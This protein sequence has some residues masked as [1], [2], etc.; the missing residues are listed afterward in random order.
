[1]SID[2]QLIINKLGMIPKEII[3]IIKDFVFYNKIKYTAERNETKNKKDNMINR[4]NSLRYTSIDFDE[5]QMEY[6]GFVFL[7][8][9]PDPGGGLQYIESAPQITCDFC[10]KCGNYQYTTYGMKPDNIICQC[11]RTL[12]TPSYWTKDWHHYWFS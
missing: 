4:I 5:I 8:N 7:R 3:D 10:I 6:T 1:M 9:Y 11:Q 2:Q 12:P